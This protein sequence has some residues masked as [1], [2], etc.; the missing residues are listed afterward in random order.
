MSLIQQIPEG[1]KRQEVERGNGS[2][3]PPI[4]FIPEKN[5]DADPDRKTPVVKIELS[6]DVE[7]RI[8]VWEG[9]GTP[10]SF[11]V[12]VMAMREAIEGI[13]LIKRHEEAEARVSEAK[14]ELQN[15]KD[16]KDVVLGQVDSTVLQEDKVRWPRPTRPSNR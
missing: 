4:P 13:G 10:E 11:L 5:E 8:N 7:S 6:N 3:Q 9:I 12:H 15:A 2:F 16:L 14:E 1:L